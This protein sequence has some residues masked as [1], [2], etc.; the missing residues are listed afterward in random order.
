MKINYL[1][2]LDQTEVKSYRLDSTIA[3]I[4]SAANVCAFRRHELVSFKVQFRH[5]Y[6][7]VT[8]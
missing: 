6:R 2:G 7:P 3:K 1:Q 8:Q 5:N 4:Y